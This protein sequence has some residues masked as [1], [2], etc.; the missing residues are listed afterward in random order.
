[1]TKIQRGVGLLVLATVIHSLSVVHG[2]PSILTGL[3]ASLLLPSRNASMNSTSD[4]SS[5][6]NGTLDLSTLNF[7]G[8]LNSTRPR[9]DLMDKLI[10]TSFWNSPSRY[11]KKPSPTNSSII[12]SSH[13]S[14]ATTPLSSVNSTMDMFSLK[15]TRR[16]L[17]DSLFNSSMDGSSNHSTNASAPR[18]PSDYTMDMVQLNRTGRSLMDT[19]FNSMLLNALNNTS[20]ASLPVAIANHTMLN[21]LRRDVMDTMLNASAITLTNSSSNTSLPSSSMNYTAEMPQ[22]NRTRRGMMDTL[23]NSSAFNN[24]FG[25]VWNGSS[26]GILNAS[27]LGKPA[28]SGSIMN[29]SL[30]MYPLN[31]TAPS[32]AV[33]RQKRNALRISGNKTNSTNN[34]ANKD[35]EDINILVSVVDDLMAVQNINMNGSRSLGAN[36]TSQGQPL[37]KRL[38]R[39]M[40]HMNSHAAQPIGPIGLGAEQK[41]PDRHMP[42]NLRPVR[43]VA[44]E[45]S[46][47]IQ[48]AANPGI[49]TA[50][51][52]GAQSVMIPG[53]D[54]LANQGLQVLSSYLPMYNM[55]MEQR[56]ERVKGFG[57]SIQSLGGSIQL[58]SSSLRNVTSF[59]FGSDV[60]NSLN[61]YGQQALN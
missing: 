25:S 16:G 10:N 47:A 36:A 61:Q 18:R 54:Q 38:V 8:Q 14:N 32:S 40:A 55:T 27:A 13:S 11:H 20:N 37:V 43:A 59:L 45:A 5:V 21:R 51:K 34:T 60:L 53:L 7:T 17:F 24:V 39:P 23:F 41:R 15:R 30:V 22:L 6:Q 1:M 26:S 12:G 2:V 48:S 31:F 57:D 35:D 58:L 9:R 49:Q 50:A 3:E 28:Y 44:Q 33:L 46:P 4:P 29:E 19:L 42:D 52:P 56:F